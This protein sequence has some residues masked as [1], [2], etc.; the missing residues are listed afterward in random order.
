[1]SC[2]GKVGAAVPPPR[3]LPIISRARSTIEMKKSLG[4][5]PA[6]TSQVYLF[7]GLIRKKAVKLYS[8]S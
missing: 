2:T 5:I 4:T 8:L 6:N 3:R 1:M 7:H